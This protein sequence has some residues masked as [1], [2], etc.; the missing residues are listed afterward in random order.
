MNLSKFKP[1]TLSPTGLDQ[2]AQCIFK[3][4]ILKK[5]INVKNSGNT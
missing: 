2:S 4:K 3:A 1:F 5:L